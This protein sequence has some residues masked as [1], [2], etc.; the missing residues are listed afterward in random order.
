M[1]IEIMNCNNIETGRITIN[2]KCLNIKYAINGTGKT[3]IARALEFIKSDTPTRLLQLKPFKYLLDKEHNPEI[4]GVE[5]MSKIAIFNEDYIG[6]YVFQQD[7]LVRNSFDIFIKTQRYEEG[8]NQINTLINSI[9]A[10]FESNKDIDS[11][12]IDFSEMSEC[13]GKSKSGYAANSSLAKGLGHGNKIKNIPKGLEMYEEFIQHQDNVKWIKWQ[14]SGNDY[15][16]ISEKCPYCTTDVKETKDLIVQVSKEYDAKLVEHLNKVINILQ[17]LNSY[18]T[19]DT[20]QNIMS[21]TSNVN[22]LTDEQIQYLVDVKKQIDDLRNKLLTIKGFNFYTLK[23]LDKVVEIIRNYNINLK[24]YTYLN[25]EST[26]TKIDTINE[27]LDEIL[28]KAGQLQG[29]INK[30]KKH[31]EDTIKTYKEEINYFLKYAGYSYYVDIIEDQNQAFKMKLKHNEIDANIENV[32]LHLSYGEKNAFALILFMFDVLK[33]SPDLIILDDP[34]SSFDKNKKFAIINMLFRGKY[35]LVDKTVLMLTHDFDPIV[36]IIYNLPSH[37]QPKPKAHFLENL[38]GVLTEK[39][40]SRNDIKTFLEIVKENIEELDNEINKLIYLR[41]LYEINDDKGEAYQ[42]LSNIF[43]KNREKPLYKIGAGQI[44]EMTDEEIN[45]GEVEINK[46]I[47][48]FSY[49][50]FYTLISSLEYMLPIYKSPCS[51]YEKLQIYRIIQNDNSDNDVIRKFVNETYHVE[52]D[53]LFQLNPCKYQTVP[54]YIIQECNK[55][56]AKL[57]EE[58]LAREL[59]NVI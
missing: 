55:D 20:N 54:N 38:N 6:Q 40:I 29:E 39:D 35:N 59:H 53:Y 10:T 33:S 28:S 47:H 1:D 19:E 34:I 31:I 16:E 2:E 25:T 23:D 14:I 5:A 18:L 43:H 11:M 56:I 26:S 4:K 17:R 51:N 42:L 21:I 50:T 41:R 24:F 13:F 49:K 45:N 44:R 7:E 3:T 22:G 48:G 15:I 46:W 30:Q 8:I 36:D 58:Y 27:S 52:N 37:F 32:K 9:K 12:I 57:E